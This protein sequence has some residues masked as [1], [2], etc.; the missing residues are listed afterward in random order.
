MGPGTLYGALSR[1]QKDCLICLSENDGR[2][3]NIITAHG[4]EALH[5]EYNRLLALVRDGMILKEGDENE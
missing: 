4:K 2:R 3:K 1:M 5:A